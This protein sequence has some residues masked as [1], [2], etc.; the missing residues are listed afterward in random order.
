MGENNV[1]CNAQNRPGMGN[2]EKNV[3]VAAGN[4]TVICLF[5]VT[6]EQCLECTVYDLLLLFYWLFYDPLAGFSLII[7]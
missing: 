6:E 5:E 7:F 1:C 4:D 3:N 2:T